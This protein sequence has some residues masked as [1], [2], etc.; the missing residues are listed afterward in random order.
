MLDF[1]FADTIRSARALTKDVIVR[2]IPT[3]KDELNNQRMTNYLV[4]N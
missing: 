4:F 1:D 2:Y 3:Y